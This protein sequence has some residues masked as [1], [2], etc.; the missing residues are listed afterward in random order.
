MVQVEPPSHVTEQLPSQ[1]TSQVD[2]SVQLTVDAG[3]TVA[4]HS[5]RAQSTSLSRAATKSHWPSVQS[6]SD[7]APPVTVHIAP[8]IQSTS[9]SKPT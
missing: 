4:V 1:V 8:A 3:P 9:L 7:S 5:E 2:M 6:R